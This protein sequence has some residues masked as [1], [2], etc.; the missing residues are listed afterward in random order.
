MKPVVSLDKYLGC[1]LINDRVTSKTFHNVV[2]K[3]ANNLTKWKA[4]SLS[5]AER[6]ILIQFTLA[7]TPIYSMQTF[8][9]PKQN[10]DELDRINRNF[11]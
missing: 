5:K 6:V 11:L 2:E 8:M 7:S 1:P 4:N 9:L 10:L 3:T